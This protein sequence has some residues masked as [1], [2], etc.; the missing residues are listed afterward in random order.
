M[1]VIV[2]VP[3]P[4]PIHT[5]IHVD[6][7]NVVSLRTHHRASGSAGDRPSDGTSTGASTSVSGEKSTKVTPCMM[8]S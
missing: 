5:H 7:H 3:V 6:V 4:I 2:P 1:M 8:T